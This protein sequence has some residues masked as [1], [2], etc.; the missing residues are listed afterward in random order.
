MLSFY[1]FLWAELTAAAHKMGYSN[2]FVKF[3]LKGFLWHV[4]WC[5]FSQTGE[6]ATT[7]LDLVI[8][9]LISAGFLHNNR[10]S[11]S[12]YFSWFSSH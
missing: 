4:L 10:H 11:L 8:I 2:S 9:P 3:F 5:I 7:N 6:N 12:I 1:S